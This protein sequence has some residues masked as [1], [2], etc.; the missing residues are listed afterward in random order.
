[1][2]YLVLALLGRELG[3]FGPLSVWYP[4]A[5]LA[6]AIGYFWGW[7]A[8]P[9]AAVAEFGSGILVFGIADTFSPAQML[10]NAVGYATI[11]VGAAV[12]VRHRGVGPRIEDLDL[13]LP[14]VV[15]AVVTST[16]SAAAF[17]IGMQVWAGFAQ[18]LPYLRSVLIWWLGDTIG[19]ATVLPVAVLAVLLRTGGPARLPAG[20]RTHPPTTTGVT[21]LLPTVMAV[22]VLAV[23]TGA[24]G[25]LFLV[26]LPIAVVAT[27]HGAAGMA[28]AT[29]ALSPGATWA[30]NRF[31]LPDGFDRVDLQLLLLGMITAG[32]LVGVAMDDRARLYRQLSSRQSHL[33]QAQSLA[34]MGSFRYDVATDTSN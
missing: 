32:H 10:V 14:L 6:L 24:V 13:H 8:L 27:R 23:D 12:L 26:V 11:Y 4:P 1:M 33:A 15:A 28:L 34:G 31:A 21:L 17:G 5:G 9:V 19:I 25:L 18:S 2:T 16:L 3:Y 20:L 22:A 29:V 30:A 7:R